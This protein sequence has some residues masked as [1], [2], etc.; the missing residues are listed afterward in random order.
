MT[1]PSE[2]QRATIEF[3]RFMVDARDEAGLATTN[4]AW[5]MVVGVLRTFR[6]RLSTQE[7]IRFANVL[8]AVVRAIFVADW[9]FHDSPLP[10]DRGES[11]VDEVRELRREHNFSPDSAIQAV[12]HALW[13]NVD[14]EAFTKVLCDLPTGAAEFWGL[15]REGN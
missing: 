15:K 1:I 11:L 8:P 2:Y 14:A 10:F 6:R 4:M 9:D 7:A 5:N 3:E 12:A 13:R